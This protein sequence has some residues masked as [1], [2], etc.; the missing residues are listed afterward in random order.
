MAASGLRDQPPGN[1]SA[2]TCQ[3]L[4]Q[5]CDNFFT[6]FGR[7]GICHNDGDGIPKRAAIYYCPL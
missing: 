6:L 3:C 5:Q 4:L 2:A 7:D 1:F